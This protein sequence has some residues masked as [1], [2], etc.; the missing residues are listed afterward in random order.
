M[1]RRKVF[2]YATNVYEIEM[3]FFKKFKKEYIL[4]DLDN[5]LDSYRAKLPSKKAK[6]F[7]ET[8]KKEGITPILL[9]NNKEQRVKPYAEVLGIDYLYSSGKPFG[10]KIRAFL[11]KLSIDPKKCFMIGDQL[12]T[13]VGSANRVGIDAILTGKLV[14]EDQWTTKFNRLLDKPLRKYMFKKKQINSWREL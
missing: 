1:C 5:T 9:S 11:Y 3:T 10:K 7:I 2:A 12:I 13:D 14:E 4:L 8:L 6:D